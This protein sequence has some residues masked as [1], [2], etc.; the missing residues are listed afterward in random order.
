MNYYAGID[1]SLECSSV[2]VVDGTGKIAREAKVASEPEALIAWFGSLGLRL[3]RIG[4]EAGPLSQ[5][6]YAA[7]REVGLAVELLETRHVKAALSAMPVKTDRNDARGIAQLMRLGWFRPVHCKSAEAQEIRALLTARKLVQSRLYDVEMS[8]RGILRGFGLKIG[9]TTPKRFA[10]RIRELVVGHATLEAVGEALLSVHAVLLREFNGFEKRV[11]EIARS[12]RQVRLLMSTPGVGAI[13]GLT[14]V[15]A[16][17]DP[18]RFKSSKSVGAH[19]GLT[20]TKYQSGE[21]DVTGRISK[22]G[23]GSVRT[24]LYEAANVILT[25]PIKGGGLKSWAMKLAKR[26]GMKKAKVA[27]ARKL[28]VILHRMLSFSSDQG[29]WPTKCSSDWCCAAVRSGA[30]T[31]AI[32]STHLR[33][34]GIIKPRQ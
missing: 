34:H 16:I 26:A 13:V 2:C 12:D 3:E 18:A 15:S 14:Y 30:V 7:L 27:L 9:R 5:W 29:D 1:V 24:A 33:S 21:T 32:G 6:L 8:L 31:A 20:P 10:E 4:L 23:D 19:F 11:R 28:A 17:D 22:L 25:R